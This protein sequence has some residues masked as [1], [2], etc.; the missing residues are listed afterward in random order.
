LELQT[1][2]ALHAKS[3]ARFRA[4]R[5]SAAQLIHI[6]EKPVAAGL[7]PANLAAMATVTRVMLNLHEVIT[8][9]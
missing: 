9:D 1:L 8:R 7:A 6:G 2:S 3:L 5:A 4:D